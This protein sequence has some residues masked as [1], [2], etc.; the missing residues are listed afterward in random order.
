MG[1]LLVANVLLDVRQM[2]STPEWTGY[3]DVVRYLR[4][5]GT[6]GQ[7]IIGS[8][9]LAFGLGFDSLLIDDNTLGYWS[10]MRPDWIVTGV[11]YEQHML[12][13]GEPAAVRRHRDQRLSQ[14]YRLVL[15]TRFYSLYAPRGRPLFTSRP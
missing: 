14:D 5:H 3:S 7:N 8:A 10:G 15:E 4:E 2:R 9:E 11:R 12:D 6:R 13:P 1:A